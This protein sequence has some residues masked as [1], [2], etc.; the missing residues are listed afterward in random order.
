MLNFVKL[1]ITYLSEQK[2]IKIFCLDSVSRPVILLLPCCTFRIRKWT[3]S[4]VNC[5]EFLLLYDQLKSA[6]FNYSIG[7][8]RQP[9]LFYLARDYATTYVC[10]NKGGYYV[11]ITIV[12]IV[13]H[14][15]LFFF[16]FLN[17]P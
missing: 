17:L 11:T 15:H 8:Q 6:A 14:L 7:C 12:R 4:Y 9:K 5:D 2:N 3:Y 1:L 13:V 16:K 10:A